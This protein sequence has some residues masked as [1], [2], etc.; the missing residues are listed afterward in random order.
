LTA[1]YLPKNDQWGDKRLSLCIRALPTVG[2]VVSL[3][4]GSDVAA[5]A[6]AKDCANS[7]ITPPRRAVVIAPTRGIRQNVHGSIKHDI[8]ILY[9]IKATSHR[10]IDGKSIAFACSC[11]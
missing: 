4:G 11:N 3:S 2:L 8:R 10:I 6:G 7:G 5:E 9:I 1:N